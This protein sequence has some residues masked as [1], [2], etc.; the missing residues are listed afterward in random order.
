M[1]EF[2]F[3]KSAFKAQTF[4]E[5][6]NHSEEY[7]RMNWQERLRVAA[8]LIAAAYGFDPEKPAQ[9]GQD[10][11]LCNIHEGPCEQRAKSVTNLKAC[12]RPFP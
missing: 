9:N 2:R 12:A 10:E 7:K 6:A 5:A 11:I 4:A 1:T 3:D 8:W